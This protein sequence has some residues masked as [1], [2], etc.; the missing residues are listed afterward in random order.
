MPKRSPFGLGI[1]IT[2]ML[3]SGANVT[4]KEQPTRTEGREEKYGTSSEY[5]WSWKV[6]IGLE[7]G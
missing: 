1:L 5:R 2:E 3:L 6:R 7:W 4:Y